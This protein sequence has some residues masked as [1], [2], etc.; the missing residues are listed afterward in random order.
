MTKEKAEAE[1]ILSEY[2][3]RMFDSHARY[4]SS[5]DEASQAE[6]YV[7]VRLR[8]T[9]RVA[10]KALILCATMTLIMS[11]AVV[12]ASALGLQIFN[13]K[14]DI[15]DGFIIITSLDEENG[16]HFYRADYITE[17]YSFKETVPIDDT[18]VFYIY[19]NDENDIEYVIEEGKN[20]DDI[21]Y[22]DN[23]GYDNYK[24]TYGEYELVIYRDQTSPRIIV[25]ME[26]EGTFIAING[27]LSMDQIHRIIDSFVIDD[28]I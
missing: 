13:Y 17:G 18:S 2:G 28:S 26:K 24:E 12:A 1:K 22:I 8:S 23:E 9:Q 5:D 16:S 7:P 6:T 15:K 27:Q 11:L 25:Y 4:F 21:V 10:K 14:F 19:E 3:R 20:K